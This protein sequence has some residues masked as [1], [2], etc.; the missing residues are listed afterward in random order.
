LYVYIYVIFYGPVSLLGS[1]TLL[2]FV[3]V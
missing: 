3:K 2:M 1:M